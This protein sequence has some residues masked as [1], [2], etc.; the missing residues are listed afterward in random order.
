MDSL[1]LGLT[2][3]VEE[4]EKWFL[5]HEFAKEV[6]GKSSQQRDLTVYRRLLFNKKDV[7]KKNK[8]VISV[9]FYSLVH[10]NE[11][12]GLLTLLETADEIINN[13]AFLRDLHQTSEFKKE[14]YE[15]QL[16]FFP[17]VNVDAYTINVEAYNEFKVK[18]TTEI[19]NNPRATWCWRTNFAE[20]AGCPL[21]NAT[22]VGGGVDLNRN[23]P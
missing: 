4:I 16:I 6:I 20:S 13:H 21:N 18:N 14:A 19:D 2:P 17:V 22:C 1:T 9:F 23:F 15:L 7:N 10:G 11:I 3:T 12:L 8:E 5:K